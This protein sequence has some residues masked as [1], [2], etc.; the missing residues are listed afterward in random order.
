LQRV[1]EEAYL[2]DVI[3]VAAAHNDHP[4]TRSYP[5]LFTPPLVSVDKRLFTNALDFAYELR[6][7]IEFHAHARGYLGPFVNDPATSWATPHVTG[8][9]ARIL[10]L[11]RDLKPFEV[12]TVLYWLSRHVQ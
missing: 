3:V 8:I 6:H 9:I 2:R 12:K 7:Q 1:I 11:Q 10:S 5:A 4:L